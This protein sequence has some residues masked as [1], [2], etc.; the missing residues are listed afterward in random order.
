MRRIA[1][2]ASS[3]SVLA[4]SGAVSAP[5]TA[6]VRHMN[7]PGWNT[8]LSTGDGRSKEQKELDRKARHLDKLPKAVALHAPQYPYER[9]ILADHMMQPIVYSDH[10]DTPDL[11]N[12][13]GPSDFFL[14]CNAADFGRT[15]YPAVPDRDHRQYSADSKEYKRLFPHHRDYLAKHHIT[16]TFF[17]ST[18]QSVN[19]SAVFSGRYDV[20]ARTDEDGKLI[21]PPPPETSIHARN[22]WFTAHY[23]NYID[24]HEVQQAPSIFLNPPRSH[25]KER[26]LYTFVM[27]SPDY[28][29]RND[30]DATF[31]L[32]YVVSNIPAFVEDNAAPRAGNVVVPY[33]P[34]L[35]TED[36]GCTRQLCFLYRQKAHVNPD[37]LQQTPDTD[38]A[39]FT[40]AD[41]SNFRFHDWNT[42][43]GK[44]LRKRFRAL[45]SVE[46]ALPKVP[47]TINFFHTKWDIQV[48][49]YY[50]KI[51]EPE[52]AFT[53]GERLEGTLNYLARSRDSFR[54]NSRYLA[55][56]TI[57]NGDKPQNYVQY[58]NTKMGVNTSFTLRSR[59]HALGADGRQRTINLPY[60]RL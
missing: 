28:P 10:L 9:S 1:A 51:G 41:R 25:V 35:P 7:H 18:P 47:E 54:I 8:S 5:T 12:N 32:N 52:P 42:K 4:T 17:S 23:G 34:P 21:P 15:Q 39:M 53:L 11:F 59:R 57:N 26:A 13:E 22:F 30:P 16:P 33:V 6:A 20:R 19:M 38:P 46:K 24:L 37:L 31:M 44:D 48:Q 43:S 55:D 50:E 29:Y 45:G 56:G 36:A 14:Y 2:A 3:C 60:T 58:T 49:E 40:F 27:A